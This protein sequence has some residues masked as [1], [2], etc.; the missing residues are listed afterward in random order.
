MSKL[1]E[2]AKTASTDGVLVDKAG[3]FVLIFT[4]LYTLKEIGL[5][6]IT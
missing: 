6:I 2:M 3:I 1:I 5:A 4:A